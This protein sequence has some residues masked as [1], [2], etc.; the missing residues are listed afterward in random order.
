MMFE[1]E[2]QATSMHIFVFW[3]EKRR[4]RRRRPSLS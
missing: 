1:A 2:Q 3:E 4:R